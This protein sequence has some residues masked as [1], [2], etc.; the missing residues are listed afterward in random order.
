[1]TQTEKNKEKKIKKRGPESRDHMIHIH[2]YQPLCVFFFIIIDILWV[3]IAG[4]LRD[5]VMTGAEGGTGFTKR[6]RWESAESKRKASPLSFLSA[7][8]CLILFGL[9]VNRKELTT[10]KVLYPD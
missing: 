4:W 8:F 3:L 7:S 6:E 10:M 1:M 5:Q 2:I 9:E